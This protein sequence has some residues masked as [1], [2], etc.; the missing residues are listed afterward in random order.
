ML[1]DKDVRIST[2][3]CDNTFMSTMRNFGDEVNIILKFQKRY[4]QNLVRNYNSNQLYKTESSKFNK[5]D[6]F[7]DKYQTTDQ[8]SKLEKK[9]VDNY[10]NGT[11][12]TNFNYMTPVY[13]IFFIFFCLDKIY[14]LKDFDNKIKK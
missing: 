13:I 5:T 11:L 4:R 10:V 12:N 1:L 7:N 14:K 6:I 2:S 8:K 9:F 3:K